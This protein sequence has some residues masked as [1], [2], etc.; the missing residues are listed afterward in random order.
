L[1]AALAR[2]AREEMTT[3]EKRMLSECI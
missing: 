1:G 3:A 2:A